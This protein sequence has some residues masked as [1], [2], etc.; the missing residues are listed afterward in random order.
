MKPNLIIFIDWFL[1]GYKAGGP[2]RSVKNLID[3]LHHDINLYLVTSDT[4]EGVDTPYA[5][6]ETGTWLDRGEYHIQYLDKDLQKAS[7]YKG[8]IKERNYSAVY[9]NSMFSPAF[10]IKPLIAAFQTNK[11][12]VLAPRGMLGPGALAIKPMKKQVF[13]KLFKV[14]GWHKKV[15][16]HLT[17]DSE[18]KEA[19]NI[20]G[21]KIRYYNISNISG[22]PPE[23]YEKPK[24]KNELKV[25]F[26]SRISYKK[27]LLSA[28]NY[29]NGISPEFN[30]QFSII[31][32]PEEQEYWK[33]CQ[34]AF[35]SLPPHIEVNYHGSVKN[36]ELPELLKDK[37]IMLLPTRSENYGHVI[38]E[39]W[40][41]GCPVLISDQTPWRDLSSKKV[42][43]DFSL[44]NTE[45]FVMGIENFAEMDAEEFITWSRSTY[46]HAFNLTN[47]DEL[48]KSYL[49]MFLEEN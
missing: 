36:E 44:S 4:D 10:A 31:G 16:W 35:K 3:L 18:V 19:K 15:T 13:L 23:F 27:N 37:H 33:T 30:I 46:D 42:G 7:Y 49:R 34:E 5:G 32:P 22:M 14:L 40:Q 39:A 28:I 9:I 41:N 47:R 20:F 2:I 26:L 29:L 6:I 12:V 38:V 1:P 17:A 45:Q 24:R 25:F 11:K 43:Y 8:L 21:K 48:K